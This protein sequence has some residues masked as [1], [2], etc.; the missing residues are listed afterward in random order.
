MISFKFD[1]VTINNDYIF[2]IEMKQQPTD[3]NFKLGMTVCRTMVLE[4]GKG[5]V[6]AIPEVVDVYEN[7]ILKWSFEVD[8][9]TEINDFVYRIFLT[10]KM[11]LLNQKFDWGNDKVQNILNAI[12]NEY[13][14]TNITLP[15]AIGNI[16]IEYDGYTTPRR[17]VGYIAEL[18]GCYALIDKGN[19][20][21]RTFGQRT[22]TLN[23]NTA[24]RYDI[25]DHHKISRVVYDNLAHF[26][27]GDETGDT[28]Y[29]DKNNFL[30]TAQAQVNS[31]YNVIKNFEWY[32]VSIEKCEV[33]SDVDFGD[34]ISFGTYKTIAEVNFSYNGG[35]S[36]GYKCKYTTM[37][38]QETDVVDNI[39][40]E[41]AKVNVTIDNQ[42][43]Q[44]ILTGERLD[45]I[46][47]E[48]QIL[49]T[50]FYVDAVNQEARVTSQETTN[51]TSY[52][53]FKGDGMRVY[54]DNNKVAEAT[55]SRFECNKGLGVQDWAIE[56]G[57][58]ANVLNFYRKG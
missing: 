2:K 9:L 37:R 14:M 23:I 26:E 56:Q 21:F 27:N 1:N 5:A 4:I 42:Q 48:T 20:T 10:D 43:A 31:I 25:G 19:L 7:N 15:A 53:A 38:F 3:F 44:I 18:M 8:E 55:S 6:A 40:Q 39:N 16:E 35:W 52:T 51:P 28:I 30:L 45:E 17:L 11:V 32:D 49:S 58:S 46:E 13:D 12:C 41:I 34:L 36:G 50:H 47:G 24:D 22:H 29:L 57:S 54:V 33:S